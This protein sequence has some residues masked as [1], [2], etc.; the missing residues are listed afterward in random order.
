M[1]EV[2]FLS[3]ERGITIFMSR[4]LEFAKFADSIISEL[5]WPSNADASVVWFTWFESEFHYIKLRSQS[6]ALGL[7]FAVLID[8]C[9]VEP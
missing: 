1:I 7:N 8:I 4:P 2:I 5:E 9:P 6:N 3:E